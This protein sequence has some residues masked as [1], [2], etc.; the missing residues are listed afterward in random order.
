MMNAL[1][2]YILQDLQT[3]HIWRII[4]FNIE[5]KPDKEILYWCKSSLEYSLYHSY[6]LL[7]G[8]S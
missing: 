3:Q 6:T 1:S 2:F 8:V 5:L 4:E 7:Q